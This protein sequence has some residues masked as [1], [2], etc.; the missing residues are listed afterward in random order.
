MGSDREGFNGGAMATTGWP[1]RIVQWLSRAQ[2]KGCKMN[3]NNFSSF[4]KA[5]GDL[6]FSLRMTSVQ[7]GMD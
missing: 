6:Q 2:W 1:T 4:K 7:E 5:A 3:L